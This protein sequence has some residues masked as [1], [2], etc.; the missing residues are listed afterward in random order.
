MSFL[1]RNDIPH[2][3]AFVK[4]YEAQEL[5]PP[6]SLKGLQIQALSSNAKPRLI[7]L[8]PVESAFELHK[9]RLL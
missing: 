5:I 1:Q 8:C 3:P 7:R 2:K 9:M 4:V 6:G